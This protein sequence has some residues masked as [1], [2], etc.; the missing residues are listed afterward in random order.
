MNQVRIKGL[1]GIE[2]FPDDWIPPNEFSFADDG[3][4]LRLGSID[5]QPAVKS[6]EAS[7]IIHETYSAFR[8][9]LAAIRRDAGLPRLYWMYE[10]HNTAPLNR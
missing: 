5:D 7:R 9:N 1:D 2:R 3:T 6:R 10:P 8:T 4:R